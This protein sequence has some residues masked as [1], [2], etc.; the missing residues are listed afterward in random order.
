MRRVMSRRPLALPRRGDRGTRPF[1]HFARRPPRRALGWRSVRMA[2]A[3]VHRLNDTTLGT[4]S[5][6]GEWLRAARL[7]QRISQRALA[8]R[9]GVS[10]SYL[11][12]IER[13]RGARP[14]VGTL[15][16]LATALGASRTDLLR[17]AGVLE[18]A[19]GVPEQAGERRLLALYRDL[20][21]DAQ[22]AV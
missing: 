17:A 6:L 13:G 16:K 12:D 4:S 19:L 8:D 18:P 11:C 9:S 14:S 10:R 22:S 7:N 3:T 15:D 21:R 20:S 2:S 1:A 5:A